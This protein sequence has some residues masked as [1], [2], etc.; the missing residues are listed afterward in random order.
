MEKVYGK[1][2]FQKEKRISQPLTLSDLQIFVASC[3]LLFIDYEA[4]AEASSNC[5]WMLVEINQWKRKPE[6]IRTK[7]KVKLTE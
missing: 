3:R 6:R 7:C 2:N 4:F 5:D 1:N